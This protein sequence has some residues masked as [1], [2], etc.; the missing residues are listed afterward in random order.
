[1]IFIISMAE[2]FIHTF[3]LKTLQNFSF[4]P[5]RVNFDTCSSTVFLQVP[6]TL[7]ESTVNLILKASNPKVT[8]FP[9]N[10]TVFFF[11]KIIL[12]MKRFEGC[13]IVVR[14]NKC[15]NLHGCFQLDE[16]T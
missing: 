4:R 14:Y 8:P 9:L 16:V 12:P 5:A 11:Y 6:F 3:E 10:A 15:V 1:M 7:K 13:L 2:A